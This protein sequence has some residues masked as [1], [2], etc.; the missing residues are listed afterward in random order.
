[1]EIKVLV[2]ILLTLFLA[3]CNPE[4]RFEAKPEFKFIASPQ[5]LTIGAH[6]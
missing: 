3:G 2:T 1:M 4:L 6:L 5:E